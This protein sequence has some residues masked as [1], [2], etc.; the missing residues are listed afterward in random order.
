MTRATFG[1]A[2]VLLAATPGVYASDNTL[3]ALDLEL[4]S[5]GRA[6]YQQYCASCHGTRAEGAPRW[7]QPDARGEM[8]APPHNSEGHT[9]KHSDAMLYR[10]V[11]HGWR[12]P[13]NK[14]N[15]LTMPAFAGIL[16]PKDARAVI[17]YL[18]TLWTSEQRR[19]QL[20][21]SKKGPFPSD[22]D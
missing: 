1:A 14:T 2:I 21:E 17:T 4:V 20:E 12:D 19:F 8:P 10:I 13:F 11:M 7:Q 18:K 3:P 15:R 6:V 22:T 5:A 9:W 16:S